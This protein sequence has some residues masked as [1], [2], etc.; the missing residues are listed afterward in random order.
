M[1]S[2]HQIDPSPLAFDLLARLELYESDLEQV[3]QGRVDAARYRLLNR[4]LAGMGA[5]TG[6]LPQLAASIM[7]IALVHSRLMQALCRR[8]GDGIA[9]LLRQ[10]RA[11]LRALRERCLALIGRTRLARRGL[12]G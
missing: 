11:A 5:C 6:A 1:S 10:Q 2:V 12:K 4:Q 7:D 9:Q 3:E 8:A